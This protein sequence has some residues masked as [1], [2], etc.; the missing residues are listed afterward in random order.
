M[1]FFFF[2][3]KTAYEITVCWS[4]DVCSSDLLH[5]DPKFADCSP[6]QTVRVHGWLSF[7]EGTDLHAE[8]KR[9]DQTGW[10]AQG[11]TFLRRDQA[12]DSGGEKPTRRSELYQRIKARLDAVA[13]IDTHDHLW[14][15][16]KLP[17]YVE[18]GPSNGMNRFCH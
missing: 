16:D 1:L 9:I 8:L 2:K 10:R 11:L 14:P 15:F 5:S 13:A 17:G 6:E 12:S 18:T 7:Y 3:Q 4:S